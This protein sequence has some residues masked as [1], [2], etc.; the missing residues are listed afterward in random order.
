[1][2]STL[3]SSLRADRVSELRLREACTATPSSP[4]RDALACM[5]DRRVGCVLV[6]ED[7]KLVGIFT[8][9]DFVNRVVTQGLDVSEPVAGAP[10]TVHIGATVQQAVEVMSQGYRHLPVV[11]DDGRPVG[12]LSIKDVVHY[13]VEYFPAKV[14]NLPPTPDLVQP[15][16][17]GA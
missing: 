15:A 2:A 16:R 13:L 5:A 11:D 9:R 10:A 1:M 12:V 17:E 7:D 4:I 3:A 14:Y 6:L 8:E